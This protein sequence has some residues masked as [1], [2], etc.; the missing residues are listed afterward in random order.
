MLLNVR[1]NQGILLDGLPGLSMREDALQYAS[2][3]LNM[4]NVFLHPDFLL[5]EPAEGKSSIG[6]EAAETMIAKGSLRPSLAKKQLII[7][8]GV[9][10]M[11][12]QAQNKILKLL[13]D[14][15]TVIVIAISYGNHVLDTV[16]S[17][18]SVV[19]YKPLCIDDFIASLKGSAYESDANIYYL[20]TKGCPGMCEKLSGYIP[21]FKNV[22]CAIFENRLQD[23]LPALHLLTEKD[24]EAITAT[25][26]VENVLYLM[27]HCFYSTLERGAARD[28]V[29]RYI[30][31]I[32]KHMSN[33]KKNTYS[34]DDFFQLLV[35]IMEV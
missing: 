22:Q 3:Y 10:L 19:E 12:E 26:F 1:L 28:S 20:L 25:P 11:T 6:V 21:M 34:K 4:E 7:V 23:L 9:D 2:S 30:E 18:L 32:N 24:K 15:E 27:E 8:D 29:I 31:L 17:R 14:V 13:E 33:C 5:I 35:D 16:R